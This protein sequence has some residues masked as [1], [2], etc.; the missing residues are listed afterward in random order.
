MAPS[1]ALIFGSILLI[2]GGVLFRL[3][4]FRV[5]ISLGYSMGQKF[6]PGPDGA[7]MIWGCLGLIVGVL[8]IQLT[9]FFI[10]IHVLNILPGIFHYGVFSKWMVYLLGMI[11]GGLLV[12]LFIIGVSS[13]MNF[14][15]FDWATIIF[16]SLAGTSYVLQI[17]IPVQVDSRVLFIILF[18]TGVMIQGYILDRTKHLVSP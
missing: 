7:Q 17:F 12:V 1:I 2:A 5:G 10:G 13:E 8:I 6:L 18:L 14:K 3:F 9:V 11:I 4:I 16:S 15:S